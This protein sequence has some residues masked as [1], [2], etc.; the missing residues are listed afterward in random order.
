M[1]GSRG[2]KRLE[3]PHNVTDDRFHHVTFTRRLAKGGREYEIGLVLDGDHKVWLQENTRGAPIA[4][5]QGSH[6][7]W[8]VSNSVGGQWSGTG[9]VN[10]FRGVIDAIEITH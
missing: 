4:F 7:G 9:V 6:D 10:G 1:G 8:K 5:N 2:A 3:L